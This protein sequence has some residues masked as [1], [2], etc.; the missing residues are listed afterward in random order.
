MCILGWVWQRTPEPAPE[1]EPI[2]KVHLPLEDTGVSL[3]HHPLD[4]HAKT[5]VLSH[6]YLQVLTAKEREER[7][8]YWDSFYTRIKDL[9]DLVEDPSQDKV[10]LL[11]VHLVLAN[12]RGK[13]LK[14]AL[15]SLS[16]G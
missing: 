6:T 10:L 11:L 9:D 1:P 12:L 5:H 4:Y 15:I 14:P 16:T 7:Q 2:P 13:I 8:H 3:T